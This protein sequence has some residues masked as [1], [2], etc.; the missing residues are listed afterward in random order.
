MIDGLAHLPVL[1]RLSS[2]IPAGSQSELYGAAATRLRIPVPDREMRM[3]RGG[4]VGGGKLGRAIQLRQILQA[5]FDEERLEL[6][7]PIATESRLYAERLIQEAVR[8]SLEPGTEELVQLWLR[9]EPGKIIHL[10]DLAVQV[11]SATL[12]LAVFWLTKPHLVEK[13]FK[14]FVP[15][16]RFYDRP[17]TSL[18]RLPRSNY[19]SPQTSVHGFGVLELHGNPWPPVRGLIVEPYK[20]RYLINV[21]VSGALKHTHSQ[22]ASK[23]SGSCPH[24]EAASSTSCS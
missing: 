14:V 8:A 11:S 4:G 9:S 3:P 19:P 18:Y 21:L 20:D 1:N 23:I 6:R 24:S 22:R 15:R 16:Y 2:S 17:Y 12:E 7:W 13:L 10:D 5:L